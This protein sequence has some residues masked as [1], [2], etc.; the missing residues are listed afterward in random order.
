VCVCVKGNDE[1]EKVGGRE[2][3]RFDKHF[4]F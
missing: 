1:P 2:G 3:S 4:I